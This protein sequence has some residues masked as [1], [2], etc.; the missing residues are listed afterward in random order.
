MR[1]LHIFLLFITSFSASTQGS[2]HSQGL[3]LASE[4]YLNSYIQKDWEKYMNYTHPNIVSL[5]GGV[6]VLVKVEKESLE[7]YKSIGFDLV[8]AKISREIK[9]IKTDKEIQAIISASIVM[10]NGKNEVEAPTKLFAISVDAGENWKFVNLSHY[11]VEN[12]NQFVPEFSA[13]LKE[14]W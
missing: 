13:D 7:M 2:D 10:T 1:Y 8:E 14:F 11:D 12:I 3:I 4:E 5:A 9:N 6:G